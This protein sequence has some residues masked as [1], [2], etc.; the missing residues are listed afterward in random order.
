MQ[1]PPAPSVVSG[2]EFT[3]V[4]HQEGS[5]VDY[6]VGGGRTIIEALV[7]G[8]EKFGG[9]LLLRAHVEEVWDHNF[10]SPWGED[11][12]F[13]QSP[14]VTLTLLACKVAA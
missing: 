5:T 11:G 6:P 1:G 14:F 9:K 3:T 13:L 8:L 10:R 2:L 7:R 12:C 4:V